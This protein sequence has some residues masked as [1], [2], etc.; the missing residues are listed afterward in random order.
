MNKLTLLLP[1][2][3]SGCVSLNPTYN[4]PEGIIPDS[5]PS[6]GI[7]ANQQN[8]A[9]VQENLYWENYINNPKLKTV[10][11]SSLSNNKDL[12]IAI[13]N[14]EAAKAQYGITESS[15]LPTLSAGL[16][17]TKARTTQGIT[18]NYQADF[19]ISA[20]ELDFFGRV[21]SLSDS[22]LESFLATQETQ[23]ATKLLVISETAK[24][25][26]TVGLYKS[27]LSIAQKT[28]ASRLQS[29]ELIKTKV[30]YG[31]SNPKDLS[32]VESTYY[33]AKSD[34]YSYQT[35][36]EQ[37]I[38][39]LNLL[40]G[41]IVD[42]KLLPENLNELDNSIKDINVIVDS[43]VLTKRPDVLSAEHQ[44]LASNANIGAA[45]AAFFP[46]ITLTT[47]KGIASSQ[48]SSLFSN[49]SNVWNFSP[50]LSIPIFDYGYNKSNLNYSKAQN[51]ISIATYEK[52]VQ[53]A[54]KEVADELA[55]KG[56]INSQIDAYAKYVSSTRNSYDLASKSYEVG[57]SD[58]LTVLTAQNSLYDAEKTSLSLE[59][60][61]LNNLI[62]LYKVIGF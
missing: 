13:A 4:K 29:L 45:R 2:F 12:R 52:T 27:Q 57:I 18:E 40:V 7:Y 37:S 32:D 1:L 19:G 38:N 56:T 59:Q 46:R 48:L 42:E 23:R 5:L 50:S 10:I 8:N 47:S 54:F 55:R 44:L 30:E 53:T 22:A 61:K 3:M 31:I 36:V 25:Y 58:Y 15:R 33:L 14:I 9:I 20:F 26:F 21:K 49:G 6:N 34:V 39:A 24:A 62:N 28:E 11:G 35:Q 17:G 60:E 16:S 43:D 41:S 51:D